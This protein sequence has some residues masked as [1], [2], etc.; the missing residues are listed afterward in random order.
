MATAIGRSVDVEELGSR[1]RAAGDGI[2]KSH[3]H[4]I[5]LL[6]KGRGVEE[7]AEVLAFSPRWVRE[8]FEAEGV[9][10]LGDWRARNGRRRT[11]LTEAVLGELRER[12][13]SPPEGGGRWSGPAVAAWLA[14][15]HGLASVH[16]QRG[17]EALRALG[18]SIQ[19][20]RPRH[21]EAAGPEERAVFKK[22]WRTPSPKRPRRTP[23]S[24]SRS[25]PATSTGSA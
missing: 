3:R 11:L 5:W 13:A 12:L 7:V 20:P 22:S 15:R 4:A 6:A 19:A 23:A 25:G 1:Y 2:A 17:W 8:R 24:G 10:G 21:P 14:R 18:F 16:P 9:E